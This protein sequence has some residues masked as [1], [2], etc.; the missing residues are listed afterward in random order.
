MDGL[1]SNVTR[2]LNRQEAKTWARTEG[3]P[4]EDRAGRRSCTRQEAEAANDTHPAD[5]FILEFAASGT[6]RKS[7]SV[8]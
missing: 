2:V 4:R 8:G 5:T 3:S 6:V 7:F 1:Q